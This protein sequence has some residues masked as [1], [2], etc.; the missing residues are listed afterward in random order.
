MQERPQGQVIGSVSDWADEPFHQH[1]RVQWHSGDADLALPGLATA[2]RPTLRRLLHDAAAR[3][4]NLAKRFGI[5]K[6]K[7]EYVF[8][9]GDRGDLKRS[10]RRPRSVHLLLS[11]RLRGRTGSADI[12]RKG[13][14]R[15]IGGTDVV[16]EVKPGVSAADVI[17]RVV[18]RH[19]PLAFTKMRTTKVRRCRYPPGT[20]PPAWT[21]SSSSIGTRNRPG[22]GTSSARPRKTRTPCST[23]CFPRR[24]PIARNRRGDRGLRRTRRRNEGPDGRDRGGTVGWNEMESRDKCG[25]RVGGNTARCCLCANEFIYLDYA[26]SNRPK[27]KRDATCATLHNR[28]AS[29]TPAMTSRLTRMDSTR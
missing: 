2:G 21:R 24:R 25:R 26:C 22:A 4:P 14:E 1:G 18:H 29:R 23:S 9:F 15:M 19:W 20:T 5:P 6:S 13:G 16:L 27:A 7:L 11:G 28:I 12:P 3:T 10:C 8:S 17:L